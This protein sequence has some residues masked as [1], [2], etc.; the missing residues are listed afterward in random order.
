MQTISKMVQTPKFRSISHVVALALVIV[1]I[2]AQHYLVDVSHENMSLHNIHYLL[3]FLPILMGAIWYGLAGGISVAILVSIL[4]APVVF[5]PVGRHIFGSW[6]EQVVGLAVYNV[7]GFITGLLSERERRKSESYRQ[8]AEELQKAYQK[9]HEQT[10]L[11]VEKEEQLRRSEKLSTLGELVAGIAHEIRNPLA[12]IRGTAEIFLDPSVSQQKKNEFAQ[13]MLDESK[14]L[15]SVVENILELARFRTLHREKAKINDLLWRMLQIVD[16]Q[17]GRKNI[18]VR[19]HFDPELP[20]LN[21]DI[22]Q[23]EHA[24]LNLLLNSVGAMSDGGTLQLTTEFQARN[25]TDEV[26][27]KITDSGTGIT[28]EH[29]SQVFE[30]FFT[31]K[32]DG[33]GLGLPIVR[34]VIKAH[35]GSI[36]IASEAGKGTCVTI[37]L[38]LDLGDVQ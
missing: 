34:R 21:L 24:I 6:A 27:V 4:Y 10:D 37:T 2:S 17:M 16:L 25:G 3:Y 11:I 13:L 22:S 14:R 7:I 19:T 31:T 36:E 23:I 32:S 18:S 15:N 8:A 28:P 12:S 35:G 30:P 20:L 33:T 38:P 9:L 1:A 26:L 29:L 5:G